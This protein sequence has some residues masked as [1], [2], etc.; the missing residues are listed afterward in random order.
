MKRTLACVSLLVLC[1]AA[2]A[3]PATVVFANA[4]HAGTSGKDAVPGLPGFTFTNFNKIH[5]SA[6]EYWSTA[7]TVTGPGVTSATDQVVIIGRG[8]SVTVPAREGVTAVGASGQLLNLS[9]LAVPRINA[10][11]EWAI[12]FIPAAGSPGLVVKR[13]AQGYETVSLGNAA[14]G[15]PGQAYGATFASGTI[16]DSGKVFFLSDGVSGTPRVAYG[17]NGRSIV[18]MEATTTLPTPVPDGAGGLLRSLSFSQTATTYHVSADGFTTLYLADLDVGNGLRSVVFEGEVVL[19]AGQAAPDVG[20]STTISTITE[21]WLD[22]DRSWY[23]RVTLSTGQ[24]AVYRNRELIARVGAPV[25]PASSETWTV[26]TDFKGDIFGNFIVTGTTNA[27]SASNEVVVLNGERVLSREGDPVD[28]NGDGLMNDNLFIHSFRDRCFM[29]GE[30]AFYVG[31]R[32]KSS[33]STTSSLGANV[34]LIRVP[35]E[36]CIADFNQDGGVDGG[37]VEAFF[38]AWEA[39]DASADVNIDGGVDGADIETFF[40]RW[41]AGC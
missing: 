38:G 7:A 5:G 19:Q 16:A 23:A 37:D 12:S 41:A 31:A 10:Q 40:D 39:A 2:V 9:G 18:A 3:E 30:R 26:I 28:L 34:S 17:D 13:T 33:A 21:C 11:G 24:A 29:T 6:G 32:L 20:G 36:V 35:F 1:G 25:T 4:A 22:V 27:A 8:S 15:V 14:S